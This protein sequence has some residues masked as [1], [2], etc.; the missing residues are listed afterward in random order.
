MM[1]GIEIKNLLMTNFCESFTIQPPVNKLIDIKCIQNI[2]RKF[3]LE[4]KSVVPS[5]PIYRL[6]LLSKSYEF[7][8]DLY[9]KNMYAP[10]NIKIGNIEVTKYR[11]RL[12]V[13]KK[14]RINQNGRT[15]R[16]TQ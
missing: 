8:Y 3:L 16:F 15:P 11:Q 9:N 7:K 2:I 10:L 12:D 14:I 1:S 13:G 4:N 6:K 5:I